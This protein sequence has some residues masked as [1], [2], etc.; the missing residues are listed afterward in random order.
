[1]AWSPDG[2]ALASSGEEGAVKLWS[3]EGKELQELKGF[4]EHVRDFSWTPDS[5][6]LAMASWLEGTITIR[7]AAT[8]ALDRGLVDHSANLLGLAFTPKGDLVSCAGSVAKLWALP[9]RTQE[10]RYNAGKNN[11]KVLAVSPDGAWLVTAGVDGALRVWSLGSGLLVETLRGHARP[12]LSLAF[13]PDSGRSLGLGLGAQGPHP[14]L[15]VGPL[16]RQGR[17]QLEPRRIK[18]PDRR[19]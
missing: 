3:A 5:K 10:R 18:G 7:E 17:A 6:R 19:A 13:R 4:K 1:M 9:E 12:V 15:L 14:S 16:L 8:G 11:A 2:K